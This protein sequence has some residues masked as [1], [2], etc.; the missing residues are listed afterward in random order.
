MLLCFCTIRLGQVLQLLA[1]KYHQAN[2]SAPSSESCQ[3]T[4]KP[5]TNPTSPPSWA[6]RWGGLHP[7]ACGIVLPGLLLLQGQQDS[8]F[9]MLRSHEFLILLLFVKTGREPRLFS[10]RF[11]CQRRGNHTQILQHFKKITL[12]ST[13]H[14]G[15]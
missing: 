4:L 13:E 10:L 1:S 12:G 11:V 8:C 9:L 3:S 14:L 2:A 7:E 5:Q 6:R 15:S